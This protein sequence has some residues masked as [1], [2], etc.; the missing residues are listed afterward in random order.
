MNSFWQ[1][2]NY[3]Q[4]KHHPTHAILEYKQRK[5][6]CTCSK[7]R[8]R[9][10]NAIWRRGDFSRGS[11]RWCYRTSTLMETSTHG[12]LALLGVDLH[13]VGDLLA[14]TNF[15]VQLHISMTEAPKR[16]LTNLGG[17]TLQKVIDVVDD[18]ELL[19]LVL[20]MII[21]LT[22]NSPH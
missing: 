9:R 5:V 15:L 22:L 10:S 17:T 6:N 2:H 3:D 20:Q 12:G 11:D 19:A 7:G 14:L 4:D 21:S 13:E 8:W 18:D 16:H 1:I